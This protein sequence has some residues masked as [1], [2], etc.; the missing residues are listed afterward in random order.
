MC[1]IIDEVRINTSRPCHS[2]LL[3]LTSYDFSKETAQTSDKD[4]A[5][6]LTVTSSPD[7]I[8]LA[9]AHLHQRALA[10]QVDETAS[11]KI[12]FKRWIRTNKK[13]SN[14]ELR[15][16]FFLC[17]PVLWVI[18]AAGFTLFLLRAAACCELNAESP[19]FADPGCADPPGDP[20]RAVCQLYEQ[21]LWL[22]CQSGRTWWKASLSNQHTTRQ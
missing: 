13:K 10:R 19:S 22:W 12:S 2:V 18:V 3:T 1:G 16:R 17:P 20:R 8:V 7:V 14:S 21:F 15:M 5:G 4:P 11:P 6:A 9:N